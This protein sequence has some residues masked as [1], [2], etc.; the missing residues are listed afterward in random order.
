MSGQNID[1]RPIL[2][3]GSTSGGGLDTMLK[4]IDKDLAT[5]QRMIGEKFARAS[6]RQKTGLLLRNLN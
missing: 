4:F 1:Q 3:K 2:D 6:K 5:L